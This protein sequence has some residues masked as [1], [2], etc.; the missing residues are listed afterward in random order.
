MPGAGCACTEKSGGKA[1][2]RLSVIVRFAFSLSTAT[3]LRRSRGSC[4]NVTGS[5]FV[6]FST[7]KPSPCRGVIFCGFIVDW[8]LAERYVVVALWPDSQAN[9]SHQPKQCNYSGRFVAR[10]PKE[11]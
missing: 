1:P 2:C 8:K 7:G 3:P 4:C 5:Y 10:S 11:R 9:N 6:R